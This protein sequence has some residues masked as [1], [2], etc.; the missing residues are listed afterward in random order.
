MDPARVLQLMVEPMVGG[1]A[2]VRVAGELTADG[3]LRLLRL[4]D[5]VVRRAEARG[6]I[7]HLLVDLANVRQFEIDGIRVLRHARLSS[8]RAGLRLLLSGM[9]GHRSALPHRVE[10]A[11]AE[12]VTVA[13]I[14]DMAVDRARI[15][16]AECPSTRLRSEAA[17]AEPL[18][19]GAS[20]CAE[21]GG[22]ES[23]SSRT[24]WR[25][26]LCGVP[27]VHGPQA[28][29]QVSPATIR[30][31]R[32][33]TRWSSSRRR[34]PVESTA[35]VGSSA[36]VGDEQ[37]HGCTSSYPQHCVQAVVFIAVS[38]LSVRST[39][40]SCRAAR[41]QRSFVPGG[42][43]SATLRTVPTT[44]RDGTDASARR[45]RPRPQRP[46]RRRRRRRSRAGRR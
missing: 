11:L 26:P 25:D 19:L 9:D 34:T 1:V 36:G 38:L 21:S 43:P 6:G 29:G 27:E 35:L 30:C 22:A 28:V 5:D 32:T 2:G 18:G 24:G 16:Q 37:M 14:D 39:T 17:P 10:A 31:H 7:S 23:R 45:Q 3:G 8:A 42:Q 33:A 20:V 41:R 44:G 4:L 40:V 46:A 13:T 12:F 15:E